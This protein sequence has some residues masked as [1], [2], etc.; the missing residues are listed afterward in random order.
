MSRY[1]TAAPRRPGGAGASRLARHGPEPPEEPRVIDEHAGARQARRRAAD[2]DRPRARHAPAS[3]STAMPAWSATTA[4][5]ELVPGH[6]GRLRGRRTGRVFTLHLRK[7]H[8]WSD[9]QPFTA[10][11]FRFF[12]EDVAPDNE[13]D[14]R[15]ARTSSSLVD[16]ELPKVEILD[17]LDRPLQLVASPTRFFLPAL[18]GRHRS[19]SSTGRPTTSSSSTRS[20]PSPRR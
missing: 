2:A 13:P 1:R 19:S 8:K 14:R 7:G 10:E 5:C 20:T 18:A 15:P 12:W 11:D 17:E 6:P 4:T 9:G 16:G 3:T